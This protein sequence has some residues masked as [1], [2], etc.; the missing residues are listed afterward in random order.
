MEHAYT[1]KN[2]K[3][4]KEKKSKK[5]FAGQAGCDGISCDWHAMFSMD[6]P[7]RVGTAARR[8]RNWDSFMGIYDSRDQRFNICSLWLSLNELAHKF[9]RRFLAAWLLFQRKKKRERERESRQ[10]GNTSWFKGTASL[11][12]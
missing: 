1:M 12:K 3:R 6:L 2:E 9:G 7:E 5:C 4:K 11:I 10:E 8:T